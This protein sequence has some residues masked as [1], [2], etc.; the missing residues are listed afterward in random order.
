MVDVIDKGEC[1]RK[2]GVQGLSIFG[3]ILG[4]LLQSHHEW[5][6]D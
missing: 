3:Y 5:L 2:C 4:S 1:S 6:S